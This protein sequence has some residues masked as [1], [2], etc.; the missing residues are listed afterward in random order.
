[1]NSSRLRQVFLASA[2]GVLF[3]VPAF[4]QPKTV[5]G[6]AY[7]KHPA[8]SCK[9]IKDDDVIKTYT[10]KGYA[11]IPVGISNEPDD[12]YLTPGK[13]HL[14]TE[15]PFGS[16]S[17]AEDVVEWRG[18]KKG[19]T[20]K[21]YAAIIRYKIGKSVAGPFRQVLLIYKITPEGN[22]CLA[23]KVDAHQSDANAKARTI[24]DDIGKTFQCG[25]DS[26]R[27]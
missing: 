26:F 7:T 22:S 3:A 5:A 10:C 20:L 24:A 1:M 23:T 6:S 2:L 15:W 19:K 4:A 11:G 27:Q 16:F 14:S 12:Y 18:E 13:K 21:P 17:F 25:R 9:L 8:E